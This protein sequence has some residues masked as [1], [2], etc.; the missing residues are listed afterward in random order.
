MYTERYINIKNLRQYP[1]LL[2][3][4]HP[5]RSHKINISC[6]LYGDTILAETSSWGRKISTPR[7]DTF[8]NENSGHTFCHSLLSPMARVQYTRA[9]IMNASWRDSCRTTK[10]DLFLSS[11]TGCSESM[12]WHTI[13]FATRRTLPWG[14]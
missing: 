4:I 12:C 9:T 10:R 13:V 2:Y 5:E 7:C 8:S 14:H 6:I 11:S 3:R 1:K